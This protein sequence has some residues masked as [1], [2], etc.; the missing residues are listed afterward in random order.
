LPL[1]A[2]ETVAVEI[3]SS[4]ASFAMPFI[5]RSKSEGE[6]IDMGGR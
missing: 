5:V 6:P 1:S 2:R 4:L 3:P